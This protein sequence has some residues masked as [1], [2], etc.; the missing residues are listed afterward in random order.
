LR[1]IDDAAWLHALLERLTN[2]L[3]ATRA[4][5]WQ[6]G[7]AP[8]DY[9]EKMLNAIIGIEIPLRRVTGSWKA[10]QNRSG[11]DRATIAAGLRASDDGKAMAG[12]VEG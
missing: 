1:I 11:A 10:S 8:P 5:P 6:I 7:D 12:L 9:I 3:E 4:R 2:R